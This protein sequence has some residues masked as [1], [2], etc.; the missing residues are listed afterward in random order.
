[1]SDKRLRSKVEDEECLEWLEEHEI[2]WPIV[3]YVCQ[4]HKENC[5]SEYE[6]AVVSKKR[7]CEVCHRRDN[8]SLGG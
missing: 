5:F 7:P 1:M 3:F 2:G 6:F 8:D 4:E